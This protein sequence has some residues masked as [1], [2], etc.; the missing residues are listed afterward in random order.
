MW[1]GV[2]GGFS[3]RGERRGRGGA[4]GGGNLGDTSLRM[5]D[6]GS[7]VQRRRVKEYGR[8]IR[9]GGQRS[10]RRRACLLMVQLTKVLRGI[11]RRDLE[12]CILNA[13]ENPRYD[14]D[15]VLDVGVLNLVVGVAGRL[16]FGD[17]G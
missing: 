7:A 12:F 3:A 16:D 5:G 11:D 14:V 17:G 13:A 2:F 1:I 8:G 4:R 15:A 10:V 9:S 6:G